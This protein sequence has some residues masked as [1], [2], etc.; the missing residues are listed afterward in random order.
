MMYCGCNQGTYEGEVSMVVVHGETL[1]IWECN[2]FMWT[3][4]N[5]LLKGCVVREPFKTECFSFVHR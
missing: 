4:V 5:G 3:V 1:E 2:I